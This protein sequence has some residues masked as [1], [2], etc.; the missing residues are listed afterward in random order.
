MF[1]FNAKNKLLLSIGVLWMLNIQRILG[2][3][4]LATPLPNGHAHNDYEKTWPALTTALEQGFV[5]IEV[6]VFPFKNTLKVAHVGFFLTQAPTLENLYFRP[7]EEWIEEHGQLFADSNQRLILMVDIKQN[8]TQAYQ[9]LRQLCLRYQHLL[10]CYYPRQDSVVYGKVDILLSG[11]KPYG[12]VLADTTRYMLIDG[13]VNDLKSSLNTRAITPRISTRYGS[14]F[15]WR[16]EGKM[17]AGELDRLRKMIEE[18]HATGRKIRFWGMPN[19]PAVWKVFLEEGVDWINV[20]Q[21]EQFRL[22]Y[23]AYKMNK[24][25]LNVK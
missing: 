23:D 4:P 20:D 19:S 7:L 6:D 25:K 21:L 11:N 24:K 2:Q 8:P 9:L 1:H 12:D 10:T 16:G 15:R 3:S 18:V 22:F 14:C 5:S 13:S 17:S